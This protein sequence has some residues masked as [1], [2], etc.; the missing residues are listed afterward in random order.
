VTGSTPN[1]NPDRARPAMPSLLDDGLDQALSRNTPPR[2]RARRKLPGMRAPM[3]P[4]RGVRCWIQACRNG[5]KDA[6]RAA[7]IVGVA[8]GVALIAGVVVALMPVRVPDF[9]NDPLDKVFDFTLLREEFNTLPVE[10][11]VELIS[12]LSG[13]LR[14][15]SGSESAVMAAFAA[16][17]V[18]SARDQLER[19]ASRLALDLFDSYATDYRT[20]PEH[21]REAFLDAK[22][23]EFV[24]TMSLLSGGD[25][26]RRSDEERLER[27]R[28]QA[29][30]DSDRIRENRPSGEQTAGVFRFLDEGMGSHATPQQRA[31]VSLLMSDMGKRMR[32]EP[33]SGRPTGRGGRGGG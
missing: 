31:R 9:A 21:E 8:A 2:A 23:V 26:D 25:P 33:I 13:R 24:R 7:I 10:R 20:V 22:Y 29:Q 11:R 1:P 15:M 27:G 3:A 6:R 5:N 32:G 30:R 18:G 16:G 12:T 19:N 28:T 17:V 14:Q 4:W